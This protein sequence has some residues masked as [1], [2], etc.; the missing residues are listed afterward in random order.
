[1]VELGLA[2]D[3][4]QSRRGFELFFFFELTFFFFSFVFELVQLVLELTFALGFARVLAV[5]FA[6]PLHRFL[7]VRLQR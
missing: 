4:E 7:F 6:F 5:T 2:A 3:R 1:M